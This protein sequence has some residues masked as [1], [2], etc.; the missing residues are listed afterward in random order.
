MENTYFHSLSIITSANMYGIFASIYV[1]LKLIWIVNIALHLTE[2][3]CLRRL[4]ADGM[5]QQ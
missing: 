4:F 2:A 1:L 5:T 3:L